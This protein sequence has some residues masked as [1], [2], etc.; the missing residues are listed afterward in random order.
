MRAFRSHLEEK[1]QDQEF[2]TL[3]DQEKEL[4][5]IGLQ[6]AEARV[7]SGLNQKELAG[8]ARITQQQ[9]S[10]IE[11]GT[12]CNLATLLKVCRALD[13]AWKFH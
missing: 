2:Q 3:F 6:I 10:K 8:R 12:N 4:F 1:L 9:L 7:K 11:N 13:L 5:Q